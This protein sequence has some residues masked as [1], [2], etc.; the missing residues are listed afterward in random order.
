[1]AGQQKIESIEGLLGSI[2]LATAEEATEWLADRLADFSDS[3]TKFPLLREAANL[4]AIVLRC[5]ISATHLT[6]QCNGR[7]LQL[8]T[9]LCE[10]SDTAS[11]VDNKMF[12]LGRCR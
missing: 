7:A 2:F 4:P 10:Q 6:L 12:E 8:T 9:L 1:M 3:R 5:V 11:P